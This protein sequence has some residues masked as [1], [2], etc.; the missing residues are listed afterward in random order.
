MLKLP[1]IMKVN[2]NNPMINAFNISS[3]TMDFFLSNQSPNT[4]AKG[5]NISLGII[6]IDKI[7]AK[8][9]ADPVRSRTYR[10]KANCNILL[11]NSDTN[12]PHIS[13]AK[14]FCLISLTFIK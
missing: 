2:A 1:L 9:V 7:E 13:R 11:P 5:E 6:S 14:S 10:D 4:P 3:V 8:T 12:L